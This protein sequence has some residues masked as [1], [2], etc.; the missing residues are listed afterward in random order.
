MTIYQNE[1]SSHNIFFI[2]FF[3]SAAIGKVFINKR[4]RRAFRDPASIIHK[5]S[6]ELKTILYSYK[7]EK[8]L[9]GI[10]SNWLSPR[11]AH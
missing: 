9:A 1:V 7:S 4:T 6:I 11:H 3:E 5:L 10:S 8:Q 2:P